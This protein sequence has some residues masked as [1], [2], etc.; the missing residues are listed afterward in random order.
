MD[1]MSGGLLIGGEHFSHNIEHREAAFDSAEPVEQ[2]HDGV[3]GL[4][5]AA[6]RGKS[7]KVR[8]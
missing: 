3:D 8:A 6:P 2:Q 5:P 7:A 4:D 1:S